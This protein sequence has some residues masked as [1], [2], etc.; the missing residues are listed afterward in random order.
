MNLEKSIRNLSQRLSRICPEAGN[1]AN[2][3]DGI[4]Y[5]RGKKI[6]PIDQWFQIKKYYTLKAAL[7]FFPNIYPTFG[8]SCVVKNIEDV[9]LKED[10]EKWYS[11]YEELMKFRRNSTYGHEKCFRCLLSPD[12]EQAA[13]F[14]GIN[15]LIAKA[16][17]RSYNISLASSSSIYPCPVLNIFECPYARKK[18][19]KE[20]NV[21]ER[22]Q[23]PN[24]FDIDD[25]FDLSE[26]AFQL[27]IAFTKAQIMTSSNDVIYEANFESGN[28]REIGHF[29]DLHDV[30]SDDPLEEKLAKVKRLSK[31]SIRNASDIYHA[32]TDREMLEKILEQGLD[33]EHQKHRDDIV[34]FFMCI[35]DYVRKEDL[36]LEQTSNAS[37]SGNNSKQ[38]QKYMKCSTC[39]EFANIHCVNCSSVWLCTDHWKQHGI[40]RHIQIL[41][42]KENY[43]HTHP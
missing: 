22:D 34:E 7:Q 15:K 2:Y 10:A 33:E 28:V 12:R 16:I 11:E 17:E 41:K 13:I 40:N 3:N 36:S 35:K 29:N 21:E 18:E 19:N 26:I 4:R 32:L 5:W 42:G 23:K 37:C 8:L 24:T 27:E 9:E 38:Q 14:I 25:L 31:V 6:I 30:F 1:N 39:Q 20:K 43:Q